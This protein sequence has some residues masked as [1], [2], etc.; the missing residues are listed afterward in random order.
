MARMPVRATMA[1]NSAWRNM[2]LSG[3]GTAPS[4]WQAQ[5][6]TAISGVDGR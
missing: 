4:R 6:A 5:K 2:A 1:R 3:A